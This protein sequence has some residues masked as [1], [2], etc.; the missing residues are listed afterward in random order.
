MKAK[1]ITSLLAFIFINAYCQQETDD[2]TLSPYFFVQ[3]ENE[4]IDQLPL[5]STTA[6]VDIAGVI[7]DI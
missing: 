5:K 1:I 6:T 7:A 2:K 4:G 3:A